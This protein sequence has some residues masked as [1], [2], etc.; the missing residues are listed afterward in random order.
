MEDEGEQL[1]HIA[2]TDGEGRWEEEED[3]R[4]NHIDYT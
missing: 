2:A 3:G 4:Y 1:T